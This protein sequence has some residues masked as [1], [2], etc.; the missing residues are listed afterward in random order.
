MK[1]EFFK[2]IK[3]KPLIKLV[4]STLAPYCERFLVNSLYRHLCDAEDTMSARTRTIAIV[5]SWWVIQSILMQEK[6]SEE[7]DFELVVDVV[8]AFSAEVEY[9][10]KNLDKLFRFFTG[11]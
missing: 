1:F 8:R 9:S 7:F 2:R 3:E 6:S 5:V 4:D 11:L 10:Q